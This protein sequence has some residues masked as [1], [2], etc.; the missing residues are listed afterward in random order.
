MADAGG[1][2]R[3]LAEYGAVQERFAALDGWT[4]HAAIDDARG[5]LGI[6]HLRSAPRFRELSGGEQARVMLAGVLL[7]RPT[8]LLLDEPTNH[9]DLA[10]C[11]GWRA[12]WAR[13]PAPCWS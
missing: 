1:A 13:S 10:A 9:L 11:A 6:A 4:F 7:A 5:H 12:T 8:V 3:E 2:R